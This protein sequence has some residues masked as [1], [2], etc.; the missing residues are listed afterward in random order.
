MPTARPLVDVEA[1]LVAYLGSDPSL[2]AELD[3]SVDD[4]RV[5]TE[6]P[7]DFPAAGAKFLQL[8]RATATT[9]DPGTGHVERA[10]VQVNGYGSTGVEAFAVIAAAYRALLDA[11]AADHL[12]GVVTA[13]ERIYGPTASPDPANDAPR[14]TSAFAVTVHP[15]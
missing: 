12:L 13:V 2:S 15:G 11:P 7:A 4:P 8:F 6:V 10:V 1:L 5:A 9:A 14:Y 3:G